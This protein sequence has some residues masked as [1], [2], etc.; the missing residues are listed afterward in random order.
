MW[1]S[2]LLTRKIAVSV[3]IAEDKVI[4]ARLCGFVDKNKKI[5]A[6]SGMRLW[7]PLWIKLA[8]C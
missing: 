7:I 2:L 8:A 5:L 1:T 4:P 6:G 3:F